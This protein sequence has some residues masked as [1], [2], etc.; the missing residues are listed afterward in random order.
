MSDHSILIVEDSEVEH[1]LY[2]MILRNVM[3]DVIVRKAYDGEEA[4]EVLRSLNTPPTL[5]LLD[6]NMPRMDG[7][8][9]LDVYSNAD[10][11]Q[12]T[13]VFVLTSSDNPDDKTRATAHSCVQGYL[14]KPFTPEDAIKL[15]HYMV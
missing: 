15:K 1:Y 12:T 2:E 13:T 4:L 3:P 14:L 5:I 10:D 6:L 9:F 7:L 11:L 8:E